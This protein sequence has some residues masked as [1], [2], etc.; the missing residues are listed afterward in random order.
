M[1]EYQNLTADVRD[2]LYRIANRLEEKEDVLVDVQWETHQ[3]FR[4]YDQVPKT[5]LK[6]SALRNVRRVIAA[7]RGRVEFLDADD[8]TETEYSVGR[9]R[10]QQGVP[11]EDLVEC[12]R[13][14]I[15]R[16]VD[17]VVAEAD[18][19]G[20]TLEA[21]LAGVRLLWA[22]SDSVPIAYLAGHRDVAVASMRSEENR[23]I[24]FVTGLIN[25]DDAG[26]AADSATY[27]MSENGQY[28]LL[29][30]PLTSGAALDV[31]RELQSTAD[32]KGFKTLTAHFEGDL[33]AIMDNCPSLIS[34]PAMSASVAAVDGPRPPSA[35]R[36][37]YV[38]TG[39]VLHCARR[40]GLTGLLHREDVS[41]LP[42]VDTCADIGE[43]LYGRL[44]APVANTR[45]GEE[46]LLTIAQFLTRQC[47]VAETAKALEIHQNSV[48]YRVARYQELTGADLT[49]TQTLVETWWAFRFRDIRGTRDVQDHLAIRA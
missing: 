42:A 25:G 6:R 21:T 45:T 18:A 33:V 15:A 47:S 29:R 3:M 4:T 35:L 20:L 40:F 7:L 41:I 13:E 17:V 14:A 2:Q 22:V 12:Y 34:V 24:A 32:R 23:R 31:E 27:H 28:W 26:V 10:A 46:I 38:V 16:I 8:D 43:Y 11:A 49:D 39:T 37:A 1:L 36:S 44:I 9:R 19:N 5:D 48:R 30:V